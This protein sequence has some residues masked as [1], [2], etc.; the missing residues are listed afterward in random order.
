MSRQDD[1]S[2]KAR[3]AWIRVLAKAAPAEL[4]AEWAAL[5]SRPAYS[6]LRRP[7]TGLAMIRGRIGGD[8]SAFN[9]G[10]ASATRAAIRLDGTETMGFGFV[11]GRDARH[12]E[13]AAAFDALLQTGAAAAH[14]AVARLDDAR[15][16]REVAE[17]RRIA[18][19]KV[20]FFA[21]TRE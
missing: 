21:M 9:L 6:F 7:E 11:L 5:P 17:S 1:D 3:Q 19:S 13:L 10:E 20:D 8:G 12:A 2:P 4:A 14:A 16:A 18:A 15:R